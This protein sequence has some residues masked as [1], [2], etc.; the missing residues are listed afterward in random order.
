LSGKYD[1]ALKRLA[2]AYQNWDRASTSNRSIALIYAHTLLL[3]GDPERGHQVGESVLALLDAESTGRP[4]GWFCRERA[5]LAVLGRYDE[6][7]AELELSV[8]LKRVHR[9]WYLTELDPVY[10]AIRATPRFQAI[11]NDGRQHLAK[12]RELLYAARKEAARQRQG[13]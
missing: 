8:Q 13:S 9:W 4:R 3:S 5:A 11:A 7:L 10:A 12:Q 6:A 2:A 1:A